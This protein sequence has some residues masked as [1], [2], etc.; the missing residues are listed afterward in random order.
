MS[1]ES[2]TRDICIPSKWRVGRLLLVGRRWNEPSTIEQRALRCGTGNAVLAPY[3][4]LSMFP[5]PETHLQRFPV[6][7]VR[8]EVVEE[9]ESTCSH[10]Q[11]SMRTPKLSHG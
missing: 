11:R 4:S 9:V 8:L 5:F 3:A 1:W 7:M 2:S 10:R 6:S